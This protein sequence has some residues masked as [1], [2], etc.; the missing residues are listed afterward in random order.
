MLF[1][2][3]KLNYNLEQRENPIPKVSVHL[4]Y[5]SLFLSVCSISISLFVLC[6][7]ILIVMIS[8]AQQLKKLS[9]AEMKFSTQLNQNEIAQPVLLIPPYVSI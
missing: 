9:H 7:F 6:Q 8:G 3:G 1:Q 4:K 2:C 5:S